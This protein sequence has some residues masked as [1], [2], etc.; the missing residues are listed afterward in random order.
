[1]QLRGVST[2]PTSRGPKVEP[3]EEPERPSR[4]KEERPRSS[5]EG[6][7]RCGHYINYGQKEEK[8]RRPERRICRTNSKTGLSFD[9]ASSSSGTLVGAC[10]LRQ[11][12]CVR[13]GDRSGVQTSRF[14]A[15]LALAPSR[16]VQEMRQRYHST[17]ISGPP[18][19]AN[20]PDSPLTRRPA[21]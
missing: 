21:R 19:S 13:G 8:R 3:R 9:H 10:P 18:S 5:G 2:W 15:P 16:V 17:S 14:S 20:D 11:G 6:V 1:M 4:R 7:K 12:G